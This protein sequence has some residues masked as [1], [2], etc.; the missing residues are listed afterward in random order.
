MVGVVIMHKENIDK[1]YTEFHKERMGIHCYPNEFLVRTMLGKYPSLN[2]SHEYVGKKVCD[3]GCG[4][5][6]N[7]ILL[8]NLGF[9]ICGFEITDEICSN[10]S[11]RM[12]KFGIP[13]DIRVGRNNNVPFDN[14][15]FDYVV[16][17]SSIYYV[18][19]DSDFQE[20]LGELVR[21]VKKGGYVIMT[22][23]H[24]D[25]FILKNSTEVKEGHYK[26]KEDPYGLRNGDIFR[27][28]NDRNEIINTFSKDFE[29][30]SIGM[31]N[32]DYYGMHIQMWL[33]VMRK[34]LG[35]KD[36]YI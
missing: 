9:D 35:Q 24:P 4:D 21:V 10:V 32:E 31:Q 26:I 27:V 17:S 23:P 36:V 2:I 30:F 33:V 15:Y 3:W 34:K 22:L 25:T 28:F 6:R 14:G 18:D 13:I 7:M 8:H 29:N 5:G 1:L 19:H 11:E 20:T 16:A 12:E